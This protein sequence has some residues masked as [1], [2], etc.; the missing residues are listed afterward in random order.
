MKPTMGMRPT[1]L[2]AAWLALFL[3]RAACM[4][5]PEFC[6]RC[7]ADNTS[8]LEKPL[9]PTARIAVII[10]HQ[11]SGTTFL[12]AALTRQDAVNPAK[13][14]VTHDKLP[15]PCCCG[16]S[17]RRRTPA[18]PF[19]RLLQQELHYFDRPPEH[20]VTPTGYFSKWKSKALSLAKKDPALRGQSVAQMLSGKVSGALQWAAA[21]LGRLASSRPFA[22]A[23]ARRISHGGLAR[24]HASAPAPGP[25]Q[26]PTPHPPPPPA[27]P[28]GGLP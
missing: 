22:T 19:P 13:N 1:A 23:E 3:S 21:R 15:S 14:K 7:F 6:R 4:P 20:V 8:D 5:M 28:A 24:T 2:L 27:D 17:P 25:A 10:G 12:H 9:L 11:K 18:P 26:T 16:G